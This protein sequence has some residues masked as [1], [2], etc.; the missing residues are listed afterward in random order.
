MHLTVLRHE[1]IRSETPHHYR[2]LFLYSYETSERLGNSAA[3]QFRN[4]AIPQARYPA[5]RHLVRPL[6]QFHRRVC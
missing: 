2:L 4:A 1:H 5:T 3:R 6:G